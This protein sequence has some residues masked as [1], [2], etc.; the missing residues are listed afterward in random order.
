MVWW[1]P[2]NDFDQVGRNCA[3]RTRCLVLVSRLLG[4]HIQILFSEAIWL[5]KNPSSHGV[6]PG[7]VGGY[8][9]KRAEFGRKHK[10][11]SALNNVW[12]LEIFK[13]S[14]PLLE[15]SNRREGAL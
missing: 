3:E 8:M 12:F 9:R 2:K 7:G 14:V 1:L 11:S 15:L 13:A 4:F 6:G 5:T 10:Q